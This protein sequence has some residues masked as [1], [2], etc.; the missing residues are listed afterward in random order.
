M[1]F[2]VTLMHG[3]K[4]LRGLDLELWKEKE[5]DVL[6]EK[7]CFLLAFLEILP[8]NLWQ[9]PCLSPTF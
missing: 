4:L 7:K 3:S 1:G 6:G 2:E 8:S 9:I 5:F